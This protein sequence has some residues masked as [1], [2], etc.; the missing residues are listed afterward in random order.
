MRAIDA[1]GCQPY[2]RIVAKK[3]KA[4]EIQRVCDWIRRNIEEPKR[5]A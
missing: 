5:C 1:H 2:I 3:R 4:S